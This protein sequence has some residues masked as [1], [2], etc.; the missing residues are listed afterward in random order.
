MNYFAD[1]FRR[2]IEGRR[3]PR[4]TSHSPALAKLSDFKLGA[5]TIQPSLRTVSGPAGSASAEP[6]VMQVLVALAEA[7][8]SVLTRD[9]LIDTC[10]NGQVVGDDSINRAI[11]EIRR[12]VRETG[13]DFVVETIPR[14]GYRL[15]GGQSEVEEPKAPPSP[16][17]GFPNRRMVI[18]GAVAA[19]AAASLGIWYS[20]GRTNPEAAA[21]VE[22]GRQALRDELPN[23]DAQGIG[24]L[25][26]A[27]QI[28]PNNAEAWG[29]LA[30]ALRNA[31][32]HSPPDRSAA[33]LRDCEEA[34]RRALALDRREG[35][36]L[37]AL[38]TVVPSFGQW[39]QAEDRLRNVLEIVPDHPAAIPHLGMLL[40]SAGF[41]RES[42]RYN[43]LAASQ[44]PLSPGRQFR[45]AWM[46]W[47]RGR[48]GE[49]DRVIDRALQLFP[50]HPAVW[51]ARMVL[52]A[53]T[54]RPHAAL[55]MVN[56][57]G[58]RPATMT[59]PGLANWRL[60]LKAL[61]TRA[62]ADIAAARQS[63]LA[64]AV[65][66]PGGAINGIMVLSTLGEI[67][68]AFEVAAGYLMRRG[69]LIG[70]LRPQGGQ[71][72]VND[73]RWRKTMM[74]FTPAVAAMQA[75]PRFMTLCQGI[76]LTEFWR[77]R[78]TRPDFLIRSLRG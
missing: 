35:H 62:P 9:D 39:S 5:A 61:E 12:I 28:E 37:T 10:W 78:G 52:F 16:I 72:T 60:S 29:L 55:A 65:R 8:G 53:L 44:D 59:G 17:A 7:R 20:I 36:A 74:L 26:R 45:R 32:E 54:G 18:G 46:L 43:A 70:P 24:F 71:M 57:E 68:A 13:A 40:Q 1:E 76:G 2:K 77:R 42:D 6:R 34:A 66:S 50:L 33:T 41:E 27:V 4:G 14:I 31:V 73:Q 69:T 11:A 25:R 22:R 49:A 75:D 21:L 3:R 58:G 64:G 23:S 19:A 30:L 48:M 15:S 47:V 63:Q 67:D 56:D 38:A 51:N